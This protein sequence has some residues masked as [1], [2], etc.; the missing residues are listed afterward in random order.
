MLVV[1]VVDVELDGRARAVAVEHVV[2]AALDVDDERHLDHHQVQFTAEILFNVL[3][4]RVDGLLRL[5]AVQ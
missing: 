2:D 3:F 5:L 1:I 4:D